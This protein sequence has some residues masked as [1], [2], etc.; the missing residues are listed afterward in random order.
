MTVH[1]SAVAASW[2][3]M[4][5]IRRSLNWAAKSPPPP[6]RFWA[7]VSKGS[8]S[9]RPRAR[10][11]RLRRFI[12]RLLSRRSAARHTTRGVLRAEVHRFESGVDVD[13]DA[14]VDVE[15]DDVLLTGV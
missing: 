2:S 14:E 12:L 3:L 9:E 4:S 6:P 1:S 13:V 15:F 5:F 10:I 11:Q 8:P 7:N